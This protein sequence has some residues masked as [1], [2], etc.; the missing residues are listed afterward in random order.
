MTKSDATTEEAK[1]LQFIKDAA[2]ETD[3]FGTHDRVAK[4]VASV[5]QTHD[6]LKVIG[7]V[8]RWG[9][10]KSTVV[11][12]IQKW[13]D[14]DTDKKTHFFIYDAWRHQSDPPRRSF[15][16]TLVNFLKLSGDAQWK[17]RLDEL[18]GQVED[19]QTTTT[20][21]LTKSGRWIL[22][23]LFLVP[24]GFPFVDHDWLNETVFSISFPTGF[25]W[26][27][28]AIPKEGIELVWGQ[29]GITAFILGCLAVCAP[30]LVATWIYLCRRPFCNPFTKH[31]WATHKPPYDKESILT[32]FMDRA[33]KSV[34]HRVTRS[35]DTTTIE[36]QL[37]FRNLMK[38]VSNS[39][40]RYVFVVD[41]LDRLPED[42]AV[43]L[44]ATIR[45]FFLGAEEKEAN[46]INPSLPTILLPID[47]DAVQ[48]MYAA[49][50][51][52]PIAKKM[53]QAFMDKTFDLT[54]RVPPPVFS[55][56][57]QYLDTKMQE[58]F[59]QECTQNWKYETGRFYEKFLASENNEVTP[60][61]INTLVNSIAVLWLQWREDMSF[62]SVAYFAIHKNTIEKSVA[63]FISENRLDIANLDE[64]WQASIAGL[65]FG[66]DMQRGLQLLMKDPLAKAIQDND[67]S[68]FSKWAA[69]P[70]FEIVFE[71]VLEGATQIPEFTGNACVLVG[72]QEF[73]ASAWLESVWRQLIK[74]QAEA[75]NNW[76]KITPSHV[77]GAESLIKNCSE[78]DVR[79]YIEPLTM[80]LS[81]VEASLLNDK[82]FSKNWVDCVVTLFDG[83]A[84]KNCAMPEIK[85]TGNTQAY[86]EVA[87]LL[88]DR[89][90]VM[91]LITHGTEAEVMAEL[92]RQLS[93][94]SQHA[95][96]EKKLFSLL[97]CKESW[98][99]EPFTEAAAQRIRVAP[100][101]E[102]GIKTSLE[103][104]GILRQKKGSSAPTH[105]TNLSNEG[106]LFEKFA[107]AHNAKLL[108]EE[109]SVLA[110][111]ILTNPTFSNPN[112]EGRAQEGINIAN[113][114]ETALND[115]PE[116][117]ALVS[118]YIDSFHSR[119]NFTLLSKAAN[120]N[121]HL[122][123]LIRSICTARLD[124]NDMGKL[125]IEDIINNLPKHLL[126]IDDAKHVNFL[127]RITGYTTFWEK[128]TAAPL[129]QNSIRIFETLIT[130]R[131]S[132]TSLASDKVTISDKARDTLFEKLQSLSS[133][134]WNQSIRSGSE[135]LQIATKL[136]KLTE[137]PIEHGQALLEAL[138]AITP[139][140]L[141]G[142]D[143]N[144]IQRWFDAAALLT[145]N[146]RQTLLRTVRDKMLH[147]GQATYL[148][149]LNTGSATLINDGH[150]EEKPDETIRVIVIPLLGNAENDA[151][152]AANADDI[153][154]W[155]K[156]APKATREFCKERM[157]ELWDGGDETIKARIKN[158]GNLLKIS[159][160]EKPKAVVKDVEAKQT[161]A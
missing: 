72:N 108:D 48:R 15:L 153:M 109:A 119:D 22:L 146:S 71:S 114:L 105:L 74:R 118:D 9:S 99:L 123:P 52:E 88:S 160:A 98:P 59:G 4:A 27:N 94:Q 132:A 101:G 66:V 124:E 69:I 6:D 103:A 44:W 137:K 47:P 157:Q 140:V 45:S 111:I 3:S 76:Q 110:L 154:K 62:Y 134:I 115:R 91:G 77:K 148:P 93:D 12:L 130:S 7:L 82:E 68:E 8:G 23:S 37:M 152:L 64:N 73:Q 63:K 40:N 100:V 54:F 96:V 50:H 42:A 10:G 58:V 31:F 28:P 79:K 149:I 113:S 53:A 70:G 156:A 34:N 24:I 102:P 67:T 158:L 143:G 147:E 144:M 121:K 19:T 41:N 129:E 85:F 112:G 150:F 161:D 51:E 117:S 159:I 29:F 1:A 5:I 43:E 21:T 107:Q 30:A 81:Q 104:L 97:E 136:L 80:R 49:G 78:V 87:Y 139:D 127:N 128:I 151:W 33:V 36:F 35:P 57:K 16:E 84:A 56:W 133:D 89:P 60:R 90:D 138:T 13:L 131:V 125:P 32:L 142:A 116:I 75:P 122:Q 106:F 2:A 46:K 55:D 83:A 39:G 61:L 17:Q 11:H 14:K 20:P 95:T 26:I 38:Q 145:E 135:P 120:D 18:N 92:G 141:S 86:L 25:S 155:I 126:C 65:Y